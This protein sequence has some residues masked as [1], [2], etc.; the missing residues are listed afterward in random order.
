MKAEFELTIDSD[1]LPCIKFRHYD[2]DNSLEQKTLNVFIN[3]V[4]TKG[5]KLVNINGHLGSSRN[6]SWEN[7]EIQI[8][9]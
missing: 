9:K 8:N 7:Y 5:C 1:G 3:A 2:Q 4:K 6:E